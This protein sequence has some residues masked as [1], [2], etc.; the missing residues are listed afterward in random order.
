MG[1]CKWRNNGIYYY[2]N[3]ANMVRLTPNAISTSF[4]K[5]VTYNPDVK[6]TLTESIR[7]LI[8]SEKSIRNH[9]IITMF[10]NCELRLSELINIDIEEVNSDTH[11]QHLCIN[12]VK[13]I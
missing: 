7:L 11:L 13:L 5:S 12:M 4:I 8:A 2:G 9:C 3:K 6:A 1:K 10:L